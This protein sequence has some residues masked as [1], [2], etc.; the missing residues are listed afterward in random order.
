MSA[1][2]RLVVTDHAIAR[3]VERCGG[4]PEAARAFLESEMVR[5]AALFGASALR[6]GRLRICFRHTAAIS[7][8]ITVICLENRVR[9]GCLARRDRPGQFER[10][11]HR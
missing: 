3:Y 1:P 7:S 11:N 9:G 6:I 10:E 8:V 5:R 4:T 2:R